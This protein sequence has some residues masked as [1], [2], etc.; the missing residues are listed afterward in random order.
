LVGEV[1]AESRQRF[2]ELVSAVEELTDDDLAAR[3]RFPWAPGQT[4]AEGVTTEFTE[5]CP[6]HME[7][8]RGWLE[9]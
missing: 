3:G 5:H 1:R 2:G 9:G 7:T 4:L 8:I 6:E